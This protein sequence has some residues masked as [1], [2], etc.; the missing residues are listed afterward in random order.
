MRLAQ[1]WSNPARFA[2]WLRFGF[3]LWLS[4]LDLWFGGFALH[5]K[6]NCAHHGLILAIGDVISHGLLHDV[7]SFFG[8]RN[9]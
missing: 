4:A 9:V 1:R 7:P 3:G 6:G 5:N 2:L 8:S